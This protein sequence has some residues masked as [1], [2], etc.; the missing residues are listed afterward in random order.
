MELLEGVVGEHGGVSLLGDGEDECVAT[1]D[2]ARRRG[3]QLVRR[4]RLVVH[5]A[6]GR[7]DA[8]LER[9]IDDDDELVVG[10]LLQEGADRLVELG[11]AGQAAALGR[12]V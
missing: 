8:V 1:A 10:V 2:R 9:G 11:Q 6:L 3:E 7:V 4:Q 5:L 12:D